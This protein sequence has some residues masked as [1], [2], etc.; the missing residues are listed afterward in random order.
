MIKLEITRNTGQRDMASYTEGSVGYAICKNIA[1]LNSLA[2]KRNTNGLI[3]FLD[4]DIRA[5]VAGKEHTQ[6][7]EDLIADV[8]KHCN[9]FMFNYR[10]LYNLYLAGTGNGGVRRNIAS[11]K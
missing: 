3:E 9:D 5:D 11:I 4:N 7:L 8:R 6:Y 10:H 1:K 2:N